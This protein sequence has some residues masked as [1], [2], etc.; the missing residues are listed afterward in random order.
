MGDNSLQNG[1]G[2]GLTLEDSLLKGLTPNEVLIAR[3]MLVNKV[4]HGTTSRM[5][6]YTSEDFK[7]KNINE[8][9]LDYYLKSLS[10]MECMF[11]QEMDIMYEMG[12]R[13]GIPANRIEEIQ[14]MLYDKERSI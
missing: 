8:P 2:T 13:L 12:E 5:K 6:R 4:L 10:D 14:F 11:R 1:A 3:F 7:A 9:S